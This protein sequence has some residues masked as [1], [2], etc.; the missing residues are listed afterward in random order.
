MSCG[1]KSYIILASDKTISPTR[2]VLHAANFHSH[3]TKE[4]NALRASR[5]NQ[6]LHEFA[7]NSTRTV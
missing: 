1:A 4:Y 7:M 5:V 6:A 2:E 3:S